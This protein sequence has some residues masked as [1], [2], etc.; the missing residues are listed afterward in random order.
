MFAETVL[1]IIVFQFDFLQ[2]R[3]FFRL[4]DPHCGFQYEKDG[5]T[6]CKLLEVLVTVPKSFL[7]SQSRKCFGKF[8]SFINI[9]L[10]FRRWISKFLRSIDLHFGRFFEASNFGFLSVFL[11]SCWFLLQNFGQKYPR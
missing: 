5:K 10:F 4:R 7:A 2:S 8:G 1:F 11:A 9:L 3:T 6:H